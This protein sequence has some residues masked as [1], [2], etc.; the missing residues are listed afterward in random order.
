MARKLSRQE[1]RHRLRLINAWDDRKAFSGPE[2]QAGTTKSYELGAAHAL[3]GFAQVSGLGEK[4]LEQVKK[5]IELVQNLDLHEYRSG[6]P[7]ARPFE[8]MKRFTREEARLMNI[9]GYKMGLEHGL[10]SGALAYGFGETR[11]ERVKVHATDIQIKDLRTFW[12]DGNIERASLARDQRRA[13]EQSK[14]GSVLE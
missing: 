3:E 9:E 12:Q 5:D 2:V 14:K 4:R 11:L 8:R 10:E 7:K 13:A 1:I 6:T